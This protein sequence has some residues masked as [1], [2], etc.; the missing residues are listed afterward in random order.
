MAK[1]KQMQMT[2]N[3]QALTAAWMAVSPTATKAWMDMISENGRFLTERFQQDLE[4]QKAMLSCRTPAELMQVQS[5]FF[6]KAITQYTDHA[7]R[8]KAMMSNVVEDAVADA[9]T[10]HARGYADVPV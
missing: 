5:E 6:A 7:A 9:R 3:A 10:G 2:E 1:Q 8:L 4:I